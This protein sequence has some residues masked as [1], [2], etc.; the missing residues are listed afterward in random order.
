M[1]IKQEVYASYGGKKR[2]GKKMLLIPLGD[3]YSVHPRGGATLLTPVKQS[4]LHQCCIINALDKNM[5][6]LRTACD[7]NSPDL[8]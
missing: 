1:S 8:N 3:N 5:D 7:E 6:N 2:E 4:N